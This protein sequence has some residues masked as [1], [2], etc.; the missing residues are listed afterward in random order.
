MIDFWEMMGRLVTDS[1]F[2]DDLLNLPMK[3]Y[4]LLP[5]QRAEIPADVATVGTANVRDDYYLLR[6]I[7]RS[8]MPDKPLSLMALG[9]LLCALTSQEFRDR[10]S[11]VAEAIEV[12]GLDEPDDPG[13]YVA[14][15]ALILDPNLVRELIINNAWRKWG[16]G[17]VSRR[18]RRILTQMLNVNVNP[19]VAN[20][21][22]QFCYVLWGSECNDSVIEWDAHTHPVAVPSGSLR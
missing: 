7:V 20:K 6:S 1:E 21:V 12:L 3:Q 18:D 17:F 13:F 10:A 14:L 9:E 16:F 22:Y 2:R 19:E 11:G 5:N 15:G 8:H 4:H